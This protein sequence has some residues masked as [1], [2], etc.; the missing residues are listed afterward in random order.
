VAQNIKICFKLIGTTWRAPYSCQVCLAKDFLIDLQIHLQASHCLRKYKMLRM[1]LQTA[2]IVLGF[3][4][5]LARMRDYHHHW[6]DVV[7]G[8]LIGAFAAW[9]VVSKDGDI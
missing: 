5:G 1:I 9:L 7:G 4:V 3:A 2:A 6:L 8:A